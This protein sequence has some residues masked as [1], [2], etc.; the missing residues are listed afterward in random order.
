MGCGCIFCAQFRTDLLDLGGGE[1]QG[2]F[3]REGRCF[4]VYNDV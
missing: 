2:I 4:G 3:G 1:G